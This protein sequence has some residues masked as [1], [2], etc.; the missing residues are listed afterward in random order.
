MMLDII[1]AKFWD[2]CEDLNWRKLFGL[3]IIGGFYIK[4]DDT[5]SFKPKQKRQRDDDLDKI[6]NDSRV[7]LQPQFI[8]LELHT[9]DDTYEVAYKM[10]RTLID[11]D[12]YIRFTKKFR[13]RQKW[14]D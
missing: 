6:E 7:P 10:L 5:Y 14:D 11:N 4:K 3:Q 12:E 8:K 1:R 9:Q 2:R 13:R